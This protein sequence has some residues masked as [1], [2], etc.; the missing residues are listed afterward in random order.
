LRYRPDVSDAIEKT[1]SAN[2]TVRSDREQQG[3]G[4]LLWVVD[5]PTVYNHAAFPHE[6]QHST[7]LGA[8]DKS[9]IGAGRLRSTAVSATGRQP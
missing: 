8:A 1:M 9:D 5:K 2:A 6:P 7:E 3:A 4:P